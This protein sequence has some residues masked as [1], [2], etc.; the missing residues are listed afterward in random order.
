MFEK[1]QASSEQVAFCPLSA[2]SWAGLSLG[3]P[4]FLSPDPSPQ[5]LSLPTGIHLRGVDALSPFLPFWVRG[6]GGR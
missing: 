2:P 3:D 6:E 1:A 5:T 4:L